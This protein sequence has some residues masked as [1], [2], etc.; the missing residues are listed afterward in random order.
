ERRLKQRG[1]QYRVRN[2]AYEDAGHSMALALWPG[3]GQP[4]RFVGGGTPEANHLAGQAAWLEIRNLFTEVFVLPA[5][6]DPA[7]PG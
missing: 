6:R 7:S 4:S 5:D 3:G 1:F 2:R